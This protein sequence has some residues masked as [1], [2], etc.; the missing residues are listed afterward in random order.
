MHACWEAGVLACTRHCLSLSPSRCCLSI[1]KVVWSSCGRPSEC[2][3]PRPILPGGLGLASRAH[4]GAHPAGTRD[5][6]PAPGAAQDAGA[7]RGPDWRQ[8]RLWCW[9]GH[10]PVVLGRSPCAPS[11]WMRQSRRRS[12]APAW[13]QV[14]TQGGL[15]YQ[16]DLTRN[17]NED[18]SKHP[19]KGAGCEKKPPQSISAHRRASMATVTRMWIQNPGPPLASKPMS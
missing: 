2:Q 1:P 16:G 6:A 11:R 9:P 13:C 3:E 7:A 19:G 15:A 18:C 10:G 8:L 5:S 4:R 12:L 14:C 17:L